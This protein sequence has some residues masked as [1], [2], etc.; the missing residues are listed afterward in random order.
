[1][2]AVIGV[3]FVF[4]LGVVIWVIATG[5]GDDDP[6]V[7]TG[8]QGTA[9]TTIVAPATSNAVTT[10]PAPMPSTSQPAAT[11]P[12]TSESTST[13][14]AVATSTSSVPVTTAAGAGPD[15]VAGD[16]AVPG[17]PMQSPLCDGSYITVLASAVGAQATP[18]GIAT[19]LEAYPGSNYLRTDQT[20]PSLTPDIDGQPIYVVFFGPFAFASDACSARSGG[21]DGAYGRQLSTDVGPNHSVACP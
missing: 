9:A 7:A 10:T 16:L 13:T 2:P 12:P 17:R 5:G 4:L 19:V 1:M 11:A 14:S 6:D 20:C 8:D 18:G 21:P 15:A 3:V